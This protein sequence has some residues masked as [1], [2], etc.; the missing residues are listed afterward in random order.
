MHQLR[1][2]FASRLSAVAAN[3]FVV[4]ALLGHKPFEMAWRGARFRLTTP[5]YVHPSL[6][7]LRG[8]MRSMEAANPNT[9]HTPTGRC[10]GAADTPTGSRKKQP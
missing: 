8:A 10:P 6:E 7:E 5:L 2:T 4:V 3:P 9:S 1:H